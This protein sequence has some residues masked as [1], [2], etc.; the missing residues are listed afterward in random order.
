MVRQG[1]LNS[2]RVFLPAMPPSTVSGNVTRAQMT[3]MMTM[4]PKGSAAVLCTRDPCAPSQLQTRSRVFA[5]SLHLTP[6]VAYDPAL[7]TEMLSNVE[8]QDG[9]KGLA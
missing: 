3:R 1:A 2:I 9:A 7:H 4:V 6:L 8:V 5:A